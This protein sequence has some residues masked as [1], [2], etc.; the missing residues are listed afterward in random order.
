MKGDLLF[1]PKSV[2]VHTGTTVFWNC[3]VINAWI[4]AQSHQS[5]FT[6]KFAVIKHAKFSRNEKNE[7]LIF[8]GF[9]HLHW[10]PHL[11]H[12]IRYKIIFRWK[13]LQYFFPNYEQESRLFPYCQDAD[14]DARRKVSNCSS[15]KSKFPEKSIHYPACRIFP[16]DK[17]PVISAFCW[18]C[19]CVYFPSLFHCVAHTRRVTLF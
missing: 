13:S 15:H 11:M 6:K 7:N 8:H 14:E 3:T 19:I 17:S 16:L 2:T 10:N 5:K 9:S 12:V 1:P 18:K 4:D